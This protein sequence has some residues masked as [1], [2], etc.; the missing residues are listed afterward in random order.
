MKD[1]IGIPW[2]KD[3]ATYRKAL[4]IF[5]DI[6][7]MP[8]S[9]EGWKALVERQLELIRSEGNI[10]LRVDIDPETFVA[11]CTSH[12]LIANSQGLIAFVNR[13]TLEYRKTGKGEVI[14]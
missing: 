7:N 8:G 12:G 4:V 5:D 11:W 3:E 6:E 13:V 10:A 1:I 2:Y 14:G 9:F